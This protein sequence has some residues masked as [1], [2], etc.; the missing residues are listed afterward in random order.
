MTESIDLDKARRLL[1]ALGDDIRDTVLE[2]RVRSSQRELASVA[3]VT[4]ADTIYQ[5]DKITEDAVRFWF[6]DHWPADAPVQIVMEG[7]E[8]GQPWCFPASASPEQTVWKCIIDPID[9]TRGLMYDKRPAW[10]LAALA[11]RS[12]SSLGGIVVAAMTELPTT[13]QWRADQVSAVRGDGSQ[14]VVGEAVDV[15]G[16]SREPVVLRPSQAV[17]LRHGFASF[18]RFFPQGKALTARIEEDFLLAMHSQPGAHPLVFEDQYISTGGQ[19][20]ELAVGHDRLLGDLRPLVH[21]KLGMESSL[22]CHPYDVAAAL[23]LT[24]LGGVVED[25]WGR[26]LDAPLDTTSP[27]AWVGYANPRLAA[28][29]RPVLHRMLEKH[30]GG[31]I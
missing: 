9:G 23:I 18:A 20:Y 30:L 2:A 7:V 21:R 10:S 26:P 22:T 24:E 17:D 28:A 29:A 6:R 15:R 4:A 8:N 12:C 16:H 14:G 27:V 25:P 13:K 5:I 11:P 19:I 1:C 3:A 31:R